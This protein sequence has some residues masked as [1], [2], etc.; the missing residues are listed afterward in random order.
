L[1]GVDVFLEKELTVTASIVDDPLTCV[2]RGTGIVV[3]NLSDF[4]HVLDS[5]VQPREIK[6]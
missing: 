5:P 2:A 4:K 1:K 6:I 3:E